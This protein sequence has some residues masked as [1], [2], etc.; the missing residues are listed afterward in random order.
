MAYGNNLVYIVCFYITVMGMGLAKWANENVS[1]IRIESCNANDSFAKLSGKIDVQVRN[2]NP[3]KRYNLFLTTDK[4]APGTMFHLNAEEIKSIEVPWTPT[5]RG[6]VPTPHIQLS[7]Q[8]PSNLF[9]AWKVRKSADFIIVY[10]EPKGQ[11]HF[12]EAVYANKDSLGVLKEIRDYKPGDS[13]KRIHWRS[14]AKNKQLRTLV[15][16]SNEGRACH[17]EWSQVSHLNFEES[18]SQLT[19][20][21]K[22]AQAKGH[23]W[24]LQLPQSRFSSS[25]GH[26]SYS[27]ALE[28]LA[29]WSAP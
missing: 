8:Y 5:R 6:R 23:P 3:N 27:K 1:A 21:L 28:Y 25:D 14:L 24:T 20:W 7:S 13:P 19:L 16:E 4:K 26:E 9:E 15:H 12:P 18:L 10:P 2:N 11:L 17:F 29:L 22:T